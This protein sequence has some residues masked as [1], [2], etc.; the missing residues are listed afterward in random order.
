MTFHRQLFSAI[1]VSH[2]HSLYPCFSNKA[3]PAKEGG[4]CGDAR[5]FTRKIKDCRP[6]VHGN[7]YPPRIKC[8]ITVSNT[9]N[10]N[11][12][13]MILYRKK[14][15]LPG[16]GVVNTNELDRRILALCDDFRGHSAK[17]VKD[18]NRGH[19]ICRRMIKWIIMKVGLTPVE[20]PL[21]RLVNKLFKGYIRE[22]YDIF[23]LTA[24]VNSATGDPCPPSREK[25]L[26]WVVEAWDQVPEELCA[27][28]FTA[29]G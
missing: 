28:A 1:V 23:S 21:D 13:L 11:E 2:T 10:S 4:K 16:A 8:Y 5:S 20:K 12:D 24:P 29:C 17:S 9:S 19:H 26:T 18:F 14:V 3:A 25:K 22:L 7:P 27:K 6:G 15:L